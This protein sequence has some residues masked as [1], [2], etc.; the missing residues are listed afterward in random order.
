MKNIGN[1][2][3]KLIEQSYACQD[4]LKRQFDQFRI[5]FEVLIAT[6]P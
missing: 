5:H 3:P 1:A 2:Y 4:S 6:G